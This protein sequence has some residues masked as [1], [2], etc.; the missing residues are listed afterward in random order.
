MWPCG[1]KDVFC[2]LLSV[3]R[4][5]WWLLLLE[6]EREYFLVLLDD[7]ACTIRIFIIDD[8]WRCY[9]LQYILTDFLRFI[10]VYRKSRGNITSASR[11][12]NSS[13]LSF[14]WGAHHENK[15]HEVSLYSV[16]DLTLAGIFCANLPENDHEVTW[17]ALDAFFHTSRKGAKYRSPAPITSKGL[18]KLGCAKCVRGQQRT[19]FYSW[20]FLSFH[21]LPLT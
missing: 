10:Y 9:L 14:N 4:L 5:F 20:A 3:S 1:V 2:R 13:L 6:R 12:W 21:V 17:W 18:I 19:F 8:D 11:A 16:W 7:D 15:A